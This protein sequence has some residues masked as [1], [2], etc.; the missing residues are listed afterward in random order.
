MSPKRL[1]VNADGFGFGSGATQGII[2]AIRLGGFIS[3]V[4][5]NANFSDVCRVRDLVE[6]FPH[7]SVGVHLNSLAG[8]PCLPLSAVRS[9]VGSDGCFHGDQFL[10]LLRRGRINANELQAEFDAQIATV[11]AYAG[12][13]LTH[14]DSQENT[15]LYYLE[16]FLSL[17]HKW[18]LSRMRNNASLICLESERPAWSRFNV[19]LRRPQIWLAHRY[20]DYQ[21]HR[22]RSAGM[23]M[24]DSLVTVG[25]PGLGNKTVFENWLRVLQNLPRG[26]HEIYCHPAYPDETLRRW[27]V[28]CDERALELSVL[29]QPALRDAAHLWNVNIIGF[30]QL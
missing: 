3:S 6:E 7:I 27:A 1:I 4:S 12:E 26:T 14:I 13:R 21:M 11:H 18:R 19:Y 25:Y 30:D 20:R 16:L 17:A 22:A 15:H 9:L 2:D 29:R 28:Y 10:P 8:R 24:A 5:V 23:R